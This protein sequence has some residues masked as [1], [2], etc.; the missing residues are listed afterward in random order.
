MK[1]AVQLECLT[2]PSDI[3]DLERH[4]WQWQRTVL[5]FFSKHLVAADLFS[6]MYKI[7]QNAFNSAAPTN[8][9]RWTNENRGRAR[10]LS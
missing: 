4:L 5:Y 1:S 7:D 8:E 3:Q 10:L 6:S 2:I 9:M